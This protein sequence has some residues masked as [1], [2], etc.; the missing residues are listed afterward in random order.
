MAAEQQEQKAICLLFGDS[1]PELPRTRP[2]LPDSPAKSYL[3]CQEEAQHHLW[4]II[5]RTCIL[6]S[7][8]QYTM[9]EGWHK[10]SN[11]GIFIG[12]RCCIYQINLQSC[13]PIFVTFVSL[14]GLPMVL[15]YQPSSSVLDYT[16]LS[17]VCRYFSQ[18]LT[19]FA[20]KAGDN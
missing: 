5:W 18:N 12:R 19:I 16:W 17:P 15:L 4:I 1:S 14:N 20:V 3:P 6:C 9:V 7:A 8:V 2:G 10:S 11:I 13:P